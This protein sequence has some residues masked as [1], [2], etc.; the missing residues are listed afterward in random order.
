L[1][2]GDGEGRGEHPGEIFHDVLPA[3]ARGEFDRAGEAWQSN[4]HKS[5]IA[6]ATARAVVDVGL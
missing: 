4:Y 3:Q 5:V 1:A 6:C 2:A